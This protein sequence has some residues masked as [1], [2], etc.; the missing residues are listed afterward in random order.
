MEYKLIRSNRKTLSICITGGEVV[1]KAPLKTSKEYIEKFLAEKSGWIAKKLAESKRKTDALSTVINGQNILY[2]GAFYAVEISAERKRTAF[3]NG[4]LLLPEKY[5]GNRFY[6]IAQWYKRI[7]KTELKL[8]LDECSARI[9]L[10]YGEFSLTNAKTKWGSCDGKCNIMLNWRLAMLDSELVE[11]VLVHEL[12]H[13][14]HHDHSAAFWQEVGKYMPR[15]KAAKKRLK[16]Y[17]ILTSL[18]R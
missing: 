13:T 11:Y 10:K 15:F 12:S 18:Y 9:G 1:V 17:S 3:D 2:H 8:L 6:A 14:V 4:K 7:A 16:T 5:E